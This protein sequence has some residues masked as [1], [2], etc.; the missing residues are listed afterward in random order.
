M[1]T[2]KAFEEF[3]EEGIVKRVSP[4]KQR[5]LHLCLESERKYHV[6]QKSIKAMGIDDTNANDY[7]EDCYNILL[8]LIRARMLERGYASSG[9]GAHQ[10]EVAFAR[11]LGLS[12][13]DVRT[14][15]QLRYFRNGI[16]YYGKRLDKEYSETVIAF[17]KRIGGVD[18]LN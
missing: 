17:T 7:I 11:N 5:A 9:P 10:A 4:D 12:E 18:R 6:L 15:D 16:L 13:S 14:L 8:F 2:A 3:L 1:K